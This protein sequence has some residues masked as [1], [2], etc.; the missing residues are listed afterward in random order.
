MSSKEGYQ[1]FMNKLFP[2][3]LL[4]TSCAS[5]DFGYVDLLRASFQ[6][7]K[8]LIDEAFLENTPYS[9]IKVSQ[10]KY[11]ATF[12]LAQSEDGIETWVGAD[13]E[14]IYTYSGL[15]IRSVGLDQDIK[16]SPSGLK[17]MR[18]NFPREDFLATIKLT[19]PL[20]NAGLLQ[21]ELIEISTDKNCMQKVVY[22]RKVLHTRVSSE[23]TFCFDAKNIPIR[24]QQKINPRGEE[25][26]IEFYYQ[27]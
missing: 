22:D 17:S 3:I 20:L 15:I 23:S 16:F 8:I 9:F 14:R 19:N 26:S 11:D 5:V 24:T 10:G 7:N 1:I 4:L 6:D 25:I 18:A 2:C 13:Y 12:I 21:M 27:Y